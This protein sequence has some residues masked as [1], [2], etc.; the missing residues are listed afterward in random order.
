MLYAFAVYNY[1]STC[2]FLANWSIEWRKYF[3]KY[4]KENLD[5]II[6]DIKIIDI[7]HFK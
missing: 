4:I 1:P 7:L 6:F 5:K 2:V 3:I